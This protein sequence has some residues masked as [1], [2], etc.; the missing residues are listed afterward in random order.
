MVWDWSYALG[1]PRQLIGPIGTTFEAAGGGIVIALVLGLILAVIRYLRV[2][3]LSPVITLLAEFIRMTPL[4]IQLYFFFYV[5]PNYH[6]LF[7]PLVTGIIGIGVYFSAYT[8]EVYRG[9]L[10]AVPAQQWE[11]AKATGLGP[12]RTWVLIIL[13]QAVRLVIPPLGNYVL[14]LFKETA[15]LSTIGVVEVL[16]AAKNIGSLS[17]RYL[18]PITIAGIF[19]LI[20]SYAGARVIRYVER[21]L[22]DSSEDG[23]RVPMR[24]TRLGGIRNPVPVEGADLQAGVPR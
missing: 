9:A 24:F 2:P 19:Y 22:Q 16:E 17:Y 3:L 8:A 21:R 11:A 14:I 20:V 1:I 13:P 12:A 5:L 6:I 15:I 23:Q 10:L 18:E 7:S 4:L